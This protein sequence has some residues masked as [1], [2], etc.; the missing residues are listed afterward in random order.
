M[1]DSPVFCVV[2][3][4]ATCFFTY[5]ACLLKANA[6]YTR[7]AEDTISAVAQLLRVAASRKA[8][9]LWCPG[10]DRVVIETG[11]KIT[12][13][14]K[15]L[16]GLQ[17]I[18]C[19]QNYF[20]GLLG[21]GRLLTFGSCSPGTADKQIRGGP[22]RNVRSFHFNSRA[23]AVLHHDGTV[24]TRGPTD[25]GGDSSQVH[26]QLTHVQE[27]VAINKA[28]AALRCDGGVVSWGRRDLCDTS[29]VQ[30]KLKK[31]EKLHTTWCAFAALLN[32]QTVVA[33]GLN[34]CGGNTSEVQ[35][36]L[37]NVREIHSTDFA[38]AALRD[39]RTVVTWG[40]DYSGGNSSSVQHQLKHVKK[41]GACD[42][43]FV[44][45]RDDGSAVTWGQA[46][47]HSGIN[48][49]QHQLKDVQQICSSSRAFAGVLSDGRVV[50]WGDPEFGGDS[51]SVQEQLVNV[52]E[53]KANRH[54]FLALCSDGRVVTWGNPG[55]CHVMDE[56][57]YL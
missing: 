21:D 13:V 4:C 11:K 29:R 37:Q 26:S 30:D 2:L 40:L 43:G 23:L 1:V 3:D 57:P 49:V 20:V 47:C 54:A 46:A 14:H 7:A 19:A 33:W 24:S 9:A 28:F 41:L 16:K 44:A 8:F 38:F 35:D 39:D 52:Q 5:G 51:S 15:K 31:A 18:G 48:S 22:F 36:Q 6:L 56:I 42:V 53:I 10:G 45:I 12:Q 55:D 27:I 17:Q 25:F 34:D 32:D 50:T